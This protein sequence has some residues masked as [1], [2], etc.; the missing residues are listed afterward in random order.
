MVVRTCQHAQPNEISAR[1]VRILA[2]CV[3]PCH[4]RLHFVVPHM[5]RNEESNGRHV[6]FIRDGGSHFFFC[7]LND[8]LVNS[9]CCDCGGL[10]YVDQGCMCAGVQVVLLERL[11]GMRDPC[12]VHAAFS[13][14]GTSGTSVNRAGLGAA[15]DVLSGRCCHNMTVLVD[16]TAVLFRRRRRWQLAERNVH[17]DRVND[18]SNVGVAG[19]TPS[20]RYDHSMTALADGTAVLFGNYDGSS[21]YTLTVSTTTATWASLSSDGATLVNTTL[22]MTH[23]FGAKRVQKNYR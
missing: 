20:A 13:S 11:S 1:N 6:H 9:G 12:F 19:N 14:G 16:G 15:G 23:F 7:V 10:S 18:H 17:I 22:Q 2:T 5:M 3:L 8:D 21:S 4:W